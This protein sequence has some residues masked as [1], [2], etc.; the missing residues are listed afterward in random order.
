MGTKELVFFDGR[1]GYKTERG[2]YLD[3]SLAAA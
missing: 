2:W 1:R 3:K